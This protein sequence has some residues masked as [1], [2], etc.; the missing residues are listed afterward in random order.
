MSAQS[1]NGSTAPM[2]LLALSFTGVRFPYFDLPLKTIRKLAI[3]Q[4]GYCPIRSITERR[5]LSPDSFALWIVVLPC[6][7]TSSFEEPIGFTVL[8]LHDMI[9]ED[10]AFIPVEVSLRAVERRTSPAIPRTFWSWCVSALSPFS[11]I[12]E[13]TAICT[14]L[15]LRISSESQSNSRL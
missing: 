1:L 5:S 11:I 7:R 6:G 4:C 3:F 13:L 8:S 10:S 12:T 15:V 9:R 14:I 2:P